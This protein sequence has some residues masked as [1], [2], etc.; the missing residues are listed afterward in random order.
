[1]CLFPL[2]D[3]TFHR[4]FKEMACHECVKLEQVV[5]FFGDHTVRPYDSPGS[6]NVTVADIIGKHIVQATLT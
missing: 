4:V 1:M 2:K 6:L 5:M 3:E